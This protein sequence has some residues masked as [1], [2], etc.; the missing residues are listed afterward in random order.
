MRE[1]ERTGGERECKEKDKREKEKK[2]GDVVPL[3]ARAARARGPSCCALAVATRSGGV[4]EEWRGPAL[5]PEARGGR[6]P[7]QGEGGEVM[8]VWD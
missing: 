1:K 5:A 3:A 4:G 6:G 7:L 2:R 8:G